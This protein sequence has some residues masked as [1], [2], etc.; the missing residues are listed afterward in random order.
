MCSGPVRA[1]TRGLAARPVHRG[2]KL[3]YVT[4]HYK[5]THMEKTQVYLPKGRALRAAQGGRTVRAQYR[6]VDPRGIRIVLMP[7]AQVRSLWEGNF[8]SLHVTP[9]SDEPWSGRAFRRH[10]A[11][12]LHCPAIAPRASARAGSCRRRGRVHPSVPV[13]IETFTFLDRNANRDVALAWKESIYRPGLVKFFLANLAI[14]S[15]LGYFRRADLTSCQLSMRR[16][17]PS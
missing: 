3:T 1:T 7:R 13:V 12:A 8:Q 5:L 9:A 2:K 14:W 16:A 6:G 4:Q 15:S 10:Y 11:V 17:L